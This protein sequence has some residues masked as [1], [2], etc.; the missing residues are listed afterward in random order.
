MF[1]NKIVGGVKLIFRSV[2]IIRDY[3][4][5]TVPYAV[6]PGSSK[7]GCLVFIKVKQMLR[8][9]PF[10]K[11]LKSVY[12]CSCYRFYRRCCQVVNQHVATEKI[13]DRYASSLSQSDTAYNPDSFHDYILF[14]QNNLHL[15]PNYVLHASLYFSFRSGHHQLPCHFI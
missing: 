8:Y 15:V 13:A 6:P 10:L 14:S 11:Y 3:C 12:Y 4:T 7:S 5:L 1:Y 2:G 9:P